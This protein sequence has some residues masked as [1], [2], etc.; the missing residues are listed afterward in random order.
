MD[1]DPEYE[2]AVTH[3]TEMAADCEAPLRD[4]IKATLHRHGVS[5]ARISLALIDDNDMARLNDRHLAQQG[6]TDVLAFDLRDGKQHDQRGWEGPAPANPSSSGTPRLV[7]GEIVVS[8]DTAKRE[9]T[10][11]GISIHAELALYVVHGVLHLLGYDD[12]EEHGAARMHELEDQ[13]LGEVGIG[14]VY[15]AEPK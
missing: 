9:A 8:V 13:I 3:L 11:R 4:A 5:Q 12:N 14:A 10:R 2:I 1:E 6:P 7:D 15:R